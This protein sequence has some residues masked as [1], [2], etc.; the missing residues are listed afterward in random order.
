M[1]VLVTGCYHLRYVIDLD[2]EVPRRNI[3]THRETFLFVS[4]KL[5]WS[6][7]INEHRNSIKSIEIAK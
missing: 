4:E 2:G 5:H 6:R 7:L 1:L 3:V